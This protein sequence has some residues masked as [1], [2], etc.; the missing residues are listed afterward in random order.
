MDSVS[1]KTAFFS[2]CGCGLFLGASLAYSLYRTRKELKE[3]VNAIRKTLEILRREIDEIKVHSSRR[4]NGD[5][6]SRLMPFENETEQSLPASEITTNSVDENDEFFDFADSN[7]VSNVVVS[8][9]NWDKWLQEVDALL[10]DTSTNK[11]ELYNKIKS[12]LEK[13]GTKADILWRL[14][15]ATHLLSIAAD[16]DGD[17]EKKKKLAYETLEYA[18]SSLEKDSSNSECHKWY[19][20]AIG[21]MSDYVSTKEK[22]ENGNEFKTHVDAAL[23]IRPLDPTL[24]HMLGRWHMEIAKLTWVEKKVAS[25]LFSKVPDST[26]DTALPCF[27]KAYELKPKWKENLLC[28]SNAYIALKKYDEAVKWIEDGLSIRVK[29]EDDQLAHEHLL[30]LQKKYSSYRNSK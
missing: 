16:K 6:G 29:G 12:G 14:A 2:V 13:F 19:A 15:K 21:S 3:E 10:E 30:G 22:I 5:V 11:T 26:Y 27:L 8:E 24:H 9:T 1:I 25:A 4:I 23:A 17:K 28:I 18:K 20:I 7:G